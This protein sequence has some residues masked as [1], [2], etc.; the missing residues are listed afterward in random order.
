M[1]ISKSIKSLFLLEDH[2]NQSKTIFMNNNKRYRG[3]EI[4]E[5]TYGEPDIP[6]AG[7]GAKLR[8]GR[9]CSFASGVTIL[10]GSE[11]CLDWVTTYPFSSFF[12]KAK[13]FQLPSRTKGDVCIGN[14]V[15]V[16]SDVLILSGVNIG[17]GAVIAAR[18]VVTR[19]VAP[20]SIVAGVPARK[21]RSRFDSSTIDALQS[22][23]WR[24]WS[25]S[26]IEDAFP[27]LMSPHLEEFKKKH[28]IVIH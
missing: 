16:G 3:F 14:D 21:I 27:L 23:A 17:N 24:N 1:S 6:Y 19:D 28:G 15:W 10:L 13:D 5:W 9:F 25:L 4:G 2:P 26:D 20:Y 18:A 12:D 8:I 11:H 22:S 7:E